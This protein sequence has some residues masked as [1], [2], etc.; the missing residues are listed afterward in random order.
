MHHRLDSALLV[1]VNRKWGQQ[2]EV[3]W[4]PDK[5]DHVM[6]DTKNNFSSKKK[7]ETV[8]QSKTDAF[9]T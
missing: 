6:D 7:L 1:V 3:E 8:T 4:K 2:Q 5:L 9:V